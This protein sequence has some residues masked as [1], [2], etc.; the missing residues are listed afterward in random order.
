MRV[1]LALAALLASNTL[2]AQGPPADERLVAALVEALKPALPYPE[3]DEHDLPLNGSTAPPWIV[4]WPAAGEARVEIIANPLNADNQERANKAEVEIQ[5]AVMAAQQKA[6]AQYERA[7]AE[8]EQT[9]RT[10]AIDGITLGDEGIA[11]ER[12]D[13]SSRVV[14]TIVS[15]PEYRIRIGSASE[16]AV[17]S[18]PF[19]AIVRI[20]ANVFRERTAANQPEQQRFHA[21]EAHL[22][23]GASTP[24]AVTR[25]GPN[26]F[27]IAAAPGPAAKTALVSLRGN[28][29]L[30]EQVMSAAQWERVHRFL[31][32][33]IE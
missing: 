29:S 7:V 28:E 1:C 33:G 22:M 18:T 5:R 16:P 11:G 23:F 24:P 17:S 14:V 31:R 8:F 10:N 2:S 26:G 12:F 4:R 19:A 27:E 20:G 15:Q 30:V 25:T 9:G 21:S 13:A 32:S 3:A 6:Q